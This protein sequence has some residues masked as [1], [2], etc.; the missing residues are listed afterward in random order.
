MLDPSTLRYQPFYCEENIYHLCQSPHFTARSPSALFVSGLGG[1]CVMWHQKQARRPGAPLSWDYHVLLLVRDPWEIWDFDTTLGF[2]VPAAM[3]L[4]RSFR[5]EIEIPVE[6]TP[7][8]R[9]VDAAELA[10]T[11]ASD[12]S[13]MRDRGGVFQRPPP[14][15]AAI[16]PRE[17]PR[18]SIASSREK[19]QSPERS[20]TFRRCSRASRRPDQAARRDQGVG[21][22]LQTEAAVASQAG[23]KASPARRACTNSRSRAAPRS[24]SWSARSPRTRGNGA[25]YRPCRAHRRRRARSEYPRARRF[26]R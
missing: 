5:P 22:P 19:T 18:T 15:W 8:F 3:Y 21:V 23:V 6:L 12:R 11:F 20:W 16:G 10:S 13:H 17:W 1:E 7:W 26:L 2:P 25:A 24:S 4:R 14:P 9:C